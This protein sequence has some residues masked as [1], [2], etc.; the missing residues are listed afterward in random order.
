MGANI[1]ICF[2][3]S[4]LN[5]ESK[6]VFDTALI[7]HFGELILNPFFILLVLFTI[8]LFWLCTG[9]NS[10]RARVA[11]VTLFCCLLLLSTGWLPLRLIRQLEQQYASAAII[12]SNMHWVVVFGGGHLERND[13]PANETLSP[14]SIKRL[15]EGVRLY[16]ELPH[17]KLLLSGGGYSATDLSDAERMAVLARSF[18]IPDSDIVLET[19]SINTVDEA[20]EIKPFLQQEPFYLV[21]SA[22]H[23]PRAM[24]LCVKQ[25]L[26]PVAAPVDYLVYPNIVIHWYNTYLPHHKN[27]QNFSVAWHEIL[28]HMWE[29]LHGQ[30]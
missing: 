5:V 13:L 28:G 26:H 7:R 20:R 3:W 10:R 23:M 6:I 15:L 4:V 9:R 17:A 16:K 11:V 29:R 14:E 12:N 19:A 21:T 18:S 1:D 27:V 22:V 25:G 8:A 30:V 24:A 2:I